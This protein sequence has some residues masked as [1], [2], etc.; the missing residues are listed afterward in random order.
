M[1]II[2][3][4]Q[5]PVVP[6]HRE[7]GDIGLRE[8]SLSLRTKTLGEVMCPLVLQSESAIANIR[9]TLEGQALSR[10]HDRA[11]LGQ[12]GGLPRLMW[13]KGHLWIAGV[14]SSHKPP[15]LVLPPRYHSLSPSVSLAQEPMLPSIYTLIWGS[16]GS[17]DPS[18]LSGATKYEWGRM[19][20]SHLAPGISLGYWDVTTPGVCSCNNH[21]I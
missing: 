16:P 13:E 14:D 9:E 20:I 8:S 17:K 10:G 4:V 5:A 15:S 1:S 3:S 21:S 12:D 2:A 6:L 18:K 19:E 11:L 7:K